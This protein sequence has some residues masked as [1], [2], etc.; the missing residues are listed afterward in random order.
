MQ[1]REKRN[2]K[3]SFSTSKEKSLTFSRPTKKQQRSF[4][5]RAYRQPNSDKT[6]P[7]EWRLLE[8]FGSCFVQEGG[9]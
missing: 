8:H 4:S 1:M 7:Y 6:Q 2:K 3:L 9:Y 5:I